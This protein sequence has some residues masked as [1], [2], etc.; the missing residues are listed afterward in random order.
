MTFNLTRGRG[1]EH[2]GR[3]PAPGRQHQTGRPETSGGRNELKAG[4]LAVAPLF[5]PGS[6]ECRMNVSEMNVTLA[7]H[8]HQVLTTSHAEGSKSNRT[9]GDG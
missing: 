6:V 7:E 5:P 9:G 4:D 1:N 3:R 2:G 8:G